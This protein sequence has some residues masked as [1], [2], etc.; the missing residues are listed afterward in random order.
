MDPAQ[1]GLDFG[2]EAGA[3]G[4]LAVREHTP[5]VVVEEIVPRKGVHW[6]TRYL[7][8]ALSESVHDLGVGGLAGDQHVDLLDRAQV[9]ELDPADLAAV[10]EH[11]P[12][13]CDL[14]H[15]PLDLGLGEIDVRDPPP[16]VDAVAAEEQDADRHLLEQVCGERLDQGVLER[17]ERAAEDDDAEPRDRRL[18]LKGGLEAVREHD[19]VLE[20]GAG[21]EGA[22]GGQA[23]V[24][25]SRITDSPSGIRAAA[26]RPIASFSIAKLASASS[27]GRSWP[28][29]PRGI[30]P[31]RIRM[32]WPRSESTA[33]SL[34]A[35]TSET[36][37]WLLSSST[38]TNA[39]SLITASIWS[40]RSSARGVSCGLAPSAGGAM[41]SAC[42]SAP[43]LLII[44]RCFLCS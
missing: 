22:G 9:G 38:R 4:E 19:H 43:R 31:P 39:L 13:T 3:G 41:G 35:V 33:R 36:P 25:T 2:S 7:A 28:R 17:P 1:A 40:R 37:N 29:P 18:E 30:A 15:L 10:G 12:P 27:N 34:R 24:P 11:D 26:A 42:S 14:Q 23:V 20:L 16:R 8:P 44:L 32:I 21:G 6:T 5:A